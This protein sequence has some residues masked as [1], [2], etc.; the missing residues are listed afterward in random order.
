MVED[1]V[2]AVDAKA[3][4]IDLTANH[5][6]VIRT[7]MGQT[8]RVPDL[9]ARRLILITL[10]VELVRVHVDDRLPALAI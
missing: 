10:V 8:H 4:A 3:A 9:V 6:V 1:A 7:S 2:D 5:A